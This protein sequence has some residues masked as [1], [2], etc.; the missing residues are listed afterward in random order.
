M[1][2]G[3]LLG[4]QNLDSYIWWYNQLCVCTDFPYTSLHSVACPR[5]Q[6]LPVLVGASLVSP[7]ISGRIRVFRFCYMISL[8]LSI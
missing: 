2:T 5:A 6:P 8:I 3:T 1:T 4:V 7:A